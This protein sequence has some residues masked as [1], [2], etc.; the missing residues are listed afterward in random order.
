M[1]VIKLDARLSAVASLVRKGSV[2]ADIGTDHAYIPAFLV[3]SGICPSAIAGDLRKMPLENAKEAIRECSLEDKIKVTVVATGFD[4]INAKKRG[5][6]YFHLGDIHE[7]MHLFTC[8][9]FY[10]EMIEC[11]E[12]TLKWF[13]IDEVKNLNLWEGDRIFLDKLIESDDYFE[14]EFFYEKD[15]VKSYRFIK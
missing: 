15:K 4:V 13:K 11:D 10:G 8:D 12:G 7:V 1:S 5:I 9:E 3:Q 2:V 14:I 6:I